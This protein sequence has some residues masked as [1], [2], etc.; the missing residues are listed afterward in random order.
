MSRMSRHVSII[1]RA[2]RLIAQRRLAVIRRQTGLMAAV[3]AGV[4]LIMLNAAAYLALSSRMDPA[5]AALVVALVNLVLAA[6]LVS[7]ANSVSAEA[8]VAPVAEVRDLAVEELEAEIKD[9][10]D[11]ARQ[12]VETVRKF[13][14]DP[15]GLGA[16]GAVGAILTTVLQSLKK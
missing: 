4:G 10:T 12:V 11:E 16:S 9:A 7:M 15:L 13:T 8:E 14:R 1:W 3:V 6:I 5:L 2:E